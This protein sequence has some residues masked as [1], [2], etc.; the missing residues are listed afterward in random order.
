[1]II[2]QIWL[3]DKETPVQMKATE[4]AAEELGVKYMM[5][6]WPML[7]S[8]FG[9][10][11]FSSGVTDFPE[12]RLL[13][14][15]EQFYTWHLL[16][17]EPCVVISPLQ[18]T[19][20]SFLSDIAGA[21]IY[22]GGSYSNTPTSIVASTNTASAALVRNSILAQYERN[23]DLLAFAR[24]STLAPLTG[25]T[26]Y[27]RIIIP[28]LRYNNIPYGELHTPGVVYQTTPEATVSIPKAEPVDAKTEIVSVEIKDEPIKEQET[29]T[30]TPTYPDGTL[31]PFW[32]PDNTKRIVIVTNDDDYAKEFSYKLGDCIIHINEARYAPFLYQHTLASHLLFVDAYPRTL[33]RL[34]EDMKFF[35]NIILYDRHIHADW[36]TEFYDKYAA[37]PSIATC[38][39]YEFKQQY[40]DKEVI[41]VGIG[42]TE[43]STLLKDI[44]RVSEKEFLEAN[45]IS[46]SCVGYKCM[47]LFLQQKED[48]VQDIIKDIPDNCL[49]KYI[50]PSSAN[51]TGTYVLETERTVDDIFGLKDAIR[52]ALSWDWEWLYVSTTLR[53]LDIKKLLDILPVVTYSACGHMVEHARGRKV[54]YTYSLYNGFFIKRDAVNELVF[55]KESR[56]GIPVLQSKDGHLGT[57]NAL[58]GS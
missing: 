11:S 22:L 36:R 34:P 31:P 39:A 18:A 28:C 10:F 25:I 54:D 15:I 42:L 23:K 47:F 19:D 55:D 33:R 40:K 2:Q 58:V 56:T 9:V 43:T 41:V 21:D 1:M 57:E 6:T 29:A 7:A 3:E 49:Y 37:H 52:Q 32:I 13:A 26:T 51:D 38:L 4:K 50:V 27:Q 5:W 35:K 16:A 14:F 53:K 12:Q 30:I 8:K 46:A 17:E 20:L 24:A 44:N 48:N 45:G